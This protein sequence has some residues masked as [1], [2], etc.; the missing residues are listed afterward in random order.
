MIFGLIFLFLLL[1]FS[2]GSGLFC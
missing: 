1:T 2:K